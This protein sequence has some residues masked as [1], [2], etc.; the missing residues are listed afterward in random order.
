MQIDM[1]TVL[2]QG[3]LSAL[4]LGLIFLF[5]WA[6]DWR[7][8]WLAWWSVP[9][10]LA[11]IAAFAFTQW[12]DEPTYIS[13]VIGN[14]ALLLTFGCIWQAARVFE[15]R[16]PIL[17]PL[18]LATIGWV[19]L[20]AWE[21]FMASLA[22]RVIVASVLA[23]G[24]LW[25][26]AVELWRGRKEQLVSRLPTVLIL[27]LAGL[28]FA[29]RIPLLW[30]LPFP[31]GALPLDP[32]AQSIL[33][34]MLFA[35]AVA[36]TILMIS[37]TRERGEFE[38]RQ[39]AL[40]DPLTGLSNR[41]AFLD[42]GQRVVLRHKRQ[43]LPLSLLMLDLDHFKSINDRYGHDAGDRVLVKF[44]SVLEANLRPADG[45]YRIGGEEFCCLLRDTGLD[46]ALVAARRI[47]T[48]LEGGTVEAVGANI[49]VT[50][51]VGVTSTAE[52]GYDLDE[53]LAQADAAV[54]EAKA[55]GRNMAVASGGDAVIGARALRSVL[56]RR[57][58]G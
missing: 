48:E 34:L 2:V 13:V 41:R 17:W 33:N 38:Q 3:G 14:V 43:R 11:A 44:S 5:Y 30:V 21:P 39:Y 49:R 4:L 22:A 19:A 37:M 8:S 58:L 36:L 54:Y 46:E 51:S 52:A 55:R 40:T 31:F 26:A 45:I 20:C 42:D 16:R 12:R 24:F 25:S 23:A 35:L 15:R 47:C 29:L 7:S 53:L 32:V 9:F 27:T 56:E 18:G 28:V 50:V 1:F 10:F 57:L 6:V